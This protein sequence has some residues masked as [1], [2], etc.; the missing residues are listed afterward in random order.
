LT[1]LLVLALLPAGRTIAQDRSD[2][3]TARRAQIEG[4]T[5]D[6]LAV[7][8]RRWERFRELPFRERDRLRQLHRDLTADPESAELHSVLVRYQQFLKQLSPGQRAEL[9]GMGH[10]RRIRQIAI[11]QAQQR[12]ADQGKRRGRAAAGR[13]AS[14]QAPPG[15][16]DV[17]WDW[18]AEFVAA[19]EQQILRSL[20]DDRR[21]SVER[22][23]GRRRQAVLMRTAMQRPRGRGGRQRPLVTQAALAD[24]EALE[25]LEARL[26]PAAR[27]KLGQNNSRGGNAMLRE[28]IQSAVQTRMGGGETPGSRLPITQQELEGFFAYD[29]TTDERAALLEMTREEMQQELRR[30]YIEGPTPQRDV[31]A[32]RRGFGPGRGPPPPS[33]PRRR[34]DDRP[35]GSEN[36]RRGPPPRG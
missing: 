16:V 21:A 7:L 15:D 29:L 33:G 8:E 2:S 17:I 30:M 25:A 10:E 28:W 4:M 9:M 23:K 34:P 31:G 24:L 19:N 18:I 6:E 1:L 26:S 3:M 35:R 11:H 32:A 13:Q 36:E 20:P 5:A 14:N 12:R 27:E 22:L